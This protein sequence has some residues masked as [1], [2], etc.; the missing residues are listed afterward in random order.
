MR[1]LYEDKRGYRFSQH[2]RQLDF[3]PHM[4]NAAEIC[5]MLEGRCEII[6]GNQRSVLSGGDIFFSFPNQIHGYEHS[7]DY[8]AITLIL[9]T[10][11]YLEPFYKTLTEY[12]PEDPFLRKGQWEHTR[13]LELTRY[14]MEDEK[15]ASEEVM[16]GYFLTIIG[17]LLSLM[18]L[19][20]FRA[21]SDNILRSILLYIHGHY[22][23]PI[24]RTDIARAIGY[25]ESY[26]SHVFSDVL[27]TSLTDYIHSLRIY[28]AARMLEQT[29]ASVTHIAS[30]LGFGSLRNF[31]RVFLKQTGMTPRDYRTRK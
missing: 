13:L 23:E 30:Y 16:Q 8:K 2:L 22:R 7:R 18:P 11:P 19:K 5:F 4:H 20:P 1:L 24:T 14:A 26:I 10:K 6:H 12:V 21:D 15:N 28:D 9:P 31:N 17:K 27:Q 29:R 3:P 25:N